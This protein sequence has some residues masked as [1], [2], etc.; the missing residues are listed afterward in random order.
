[1]RTEH[2][3]MAPKKKKWH[4]GDHLEVVR[5]THQGHAGKVVRTSDCYLWF[6]SERDGKVKQSAKTSCQCPK[7]TSTTCRDDPLIRTFLDERTSLA[8]KE[9]SRAVLVASLMEGTFPCTPEER[10]RWIQTVTAEFGTL[11][12]E[13]VLNMRDV[14]DIV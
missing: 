6:R 11:F 8:V 4:V 14:M 7:K 13:E 3:A 10:A 1:M 12:C 2:E 9:A 5:G